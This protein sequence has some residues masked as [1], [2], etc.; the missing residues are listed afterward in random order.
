MTF[1][2]KPY[3]V[4]R[5]TNDVNLDISTRMRKKVVFSSPYFS[6]V[7]KNEVL[8]VFQAELSRLPTCLSHK[9]LMLINSLLVCHFASRWI[10][11]APRQKD[12]C[13]SKSSHQVSSFNGKKVDSSSS[14]WIW[15]P[16]K[17][18]CGFAG[19]SSLTIFSAGPTFAKLPIGKL[20]K[21]C[22]TRRILWVPLWS[23]ISNRKCSWRTSANV[24]T[25]LPKAQEPLE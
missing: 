3:R 24:W 9:N 12:L 22:P 25:G 17:K 21:A 19:P 11:S 23:S 15:V 2:T 10:P 5:G 1:L 13:F 7:C 14:P 4:K 20:H 16:L 8:L 18:V 6:F